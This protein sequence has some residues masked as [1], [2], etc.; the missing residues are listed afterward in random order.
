MLHRDDRASARVRRLLRQAMVDYGAGNGL[1]PEIADR[2]VRQLFLSAGR[3]MSAGAMTPADH[4]KQM[5]DYAGTT[6]AGLEAME[7][8]SISKD[9]A[10]GL[11]AAIARTRS[12]G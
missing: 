12:I 8:S 2:A 4:V 6:A 11:D 10:E 9:I 3:V 7:R 5:I 1:P